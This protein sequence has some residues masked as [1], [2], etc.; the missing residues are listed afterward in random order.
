MVVPSA[1]FGG[2]LRCT[3][4][5][6]AMWLGFSIVPPSSFSFCWTLDFQQGIRLSH[7]LTTKVFGNLKV[8]DAA[9]PCGWW[10]RADSRCESMTFSRKEP[11]SS[12]RMPSD[13]FRLYLKSRIS[14]LSEDLWSYFSRKRLLGVVLCYH[15]CPASLSN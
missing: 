13:L 14:F 7:L 4:S 5:L 8:R 6:L 12:P 2:K 1:F 15:D 11:L 9:H 10:S 3:T